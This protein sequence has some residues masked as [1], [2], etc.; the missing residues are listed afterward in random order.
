VVLVVVVYYPLPFF[1][2]QLLVFIAKDVFKFPWCDLPILIEIE[3]VKGLFEVFLSENV[4][5]V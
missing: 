4:V 3:E 2:F 1:I 5:Q